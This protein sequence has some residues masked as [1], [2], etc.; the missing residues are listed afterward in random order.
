VIDFIGEENLSLKDV[1]IKGVELLKRRKVS[2]K[3]EKYLNLIGKLRKKV[4]GGFF[5]GFYSGGT[6]ANEAVFFFEKSN[7][8]VY[9]NVTKKKEFLLPTGFKSKENTV[10]DMGEDEFTRGKPHPM[11]DFSLR[12]ERIVKEAKNKK[13]KI[14]FFDIVLGFNAHPDPAEEIKDAVKRIRRKDLVILS[15][16]TGVKEDP[17]NLLI[18]EKKLKELGILTFKTHKSMIDFIIKLIK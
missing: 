12:K 3:E 15:S 7:I 8:K 10:V 13:V 16:I 4:K 9:S 6:L 2:L 11:I 1:A 5:R 14:I 17:Q 18:Q